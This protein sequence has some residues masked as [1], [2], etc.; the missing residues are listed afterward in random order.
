MYFVVCAT[1][2]VDNDSCL[3]L[4]LPCI[5][6]ERSY[7]SYVAEIGE[8][9]NR[10]RLRKLMKKAYK[11]RRKWILDEAPPVAAVLSKFPCLKQT[12]C[13]SLEYCVDY[14]CVICVPY[15]LIL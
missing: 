3:L 10:K 12:K 7:D 13:V 15:S 4:T 9:P 8:E 6:D 2:L 14:V 1:V 5:D 11:L